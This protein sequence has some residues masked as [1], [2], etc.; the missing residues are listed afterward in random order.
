[1]TVIA[2]ISKSSHAK[3]VADWATA[4][5]DPGESVEYICLRVSEERVSDTAT[6][7]K[8]EEI[9]IAKENINAIQSGAPVAEVLEA[10]R[11]S[12]ARLLVTT[13]F[14]MADAD[15]RPPAP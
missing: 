15:G 11:R 6:V 13:D 1:M 5:K 3:L 14:S 7:S 9:G 12:K 4:L 8:L 10:C 2:F